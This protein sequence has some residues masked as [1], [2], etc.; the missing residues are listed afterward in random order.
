MPTELRRVISADGVFLDGA[1]ETPAIAATSNL[2]VDAFLLVHGTGSNFYDAG[3]LESFEQQASATDHAVLRI[4]TRGH[5]GVSSIPATQGSVPGGAAYE[6]IDDCRFDL[7]AWLDDLVSLGYSRIVLV[8]H[9][10]GAVKSILTMATQPH[11]AVRYLVGISPPRFHHAR[12]MADSRTDAFRAD[13][14]RACRLVDEGCAEELMCVQQPLPM[15]LTANG[16]LAKYGP[17]DDFDVVTHLPNISRPTLIVVGSDSVKNSPAFA[18][19]PQAIDDVAKTNERLSVKIVE[20]AN[21]G[22]SSHLDIPF[23]CVERWLTSQA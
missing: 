6:T 23:A 12:L 11:S 7:H 19:L 5:D 16:F 21:T 14:A 4:N 18:D 22:Y 3:V 9:S 20:G 15:L 8:G 10:M 17:H 1:L 13:Y 2:P